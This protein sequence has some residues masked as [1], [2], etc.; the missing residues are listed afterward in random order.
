MTK[1]TKKTKDLDPKAKAK[2]VKGGINVTD[3]VFDQLKPSDSQ[4]LK[5]ATKDLTQGKVNPK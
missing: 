5:R 4:N 2:T 3:T 1:R